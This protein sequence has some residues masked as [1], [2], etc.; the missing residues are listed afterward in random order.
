MNIELSSTPP[1][2]SRDKLIKDL[3]ELKALHAGRYWS[4]LKLLHRD[5]P[6]AQLLLSCFSKENMSENEVRIVADIT[7]ANLVLQI[8]LVEVASSYE[9]WT[10]LE[11]IESFDDFVEKNKIDLD[12]F[13]RYKQKPI[14]SEIVESIKAFAFEMEAQQ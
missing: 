5:K 4:H 12:H 1:E 9:D 10:E 14:Y 8:E 13:E 7:H 3:I 11:G 2:I 6:L